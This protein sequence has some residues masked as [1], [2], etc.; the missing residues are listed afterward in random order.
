MCSPG[1]GRGGGLP[2]FRI[3]LSGLSAIPN[4]GISGND[5]RPIRMEL[6]CYGCW[7][8]ADCGC[9]N[10]GDPVLAGSWPSG[11]RSRHPILEHSGAAIPL[12]AS[13]LR[14]GAL[15]RV[16]ATAN[17]LIF[18]PC[19]SNSRFLSFRA[20]PGARARSAI[21]IPPSPQLKA[22]NEIGLIRNGAAPGVNRGVFSHLLNSL[23]NSRDAN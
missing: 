11:T 14:R 2:E 18:P 20:L 16:S 5:G 8:Q 6:R 1:R 22:R 13:R 3:C 17:L 21:K 7:L 10:P 9:P 23:R 4:S 15:R 19:S 12:P